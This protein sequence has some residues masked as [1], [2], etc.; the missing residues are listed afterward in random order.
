MNNFKTRMF[1]IMIMMYIIGHIPYNRLKV[2]P[3][4]NGVIIDIIHPIENVNEEVKSILSIMFIKN[5]IWLFIEPTSYRIPFSKRAFKLLEYAID[6]PEEF[7]INFN[8]TEY[9]DY[10]DENFGEFY[11]EI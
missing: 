8:L 6:N 11:R 9:M 3:Q 1:Y 5:K 2:T 7:S 10:I 4:L